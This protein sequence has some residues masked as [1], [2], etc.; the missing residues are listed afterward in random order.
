MKASLMIIYLKHYSTYAFD[1]YMDKRNHLPN[2]N[3]KKPSS[4]LKREFAWEFIMKQFYIHI[5]IFKQ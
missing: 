3:T 5:G 1:Y 4:I 2:L